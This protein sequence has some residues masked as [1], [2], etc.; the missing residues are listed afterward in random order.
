[1]VG[2][3]F[4][5]FATNNGIAVGS[6][7]GRAALRTIP[8]QALDIVAA[9]ADRIYFRTYLPETFDK[10]I[11]YEISS[12]R[13]VEPFTIENTQLLAASGFN[14]F[15]RGSVLYSDCSGV[16]T[17]LCAQ[18]LADGTTFM[19]GSSSR[20]AVGCTVSD[21]AYR[22]GGPYLLGIQRLSLVRRGTSQVIVSPDA[23]DSDVRPFL[24]AVVGDR[25]YFSPGRYPSSGSEGATYI[26]L[27]YEMPLPPEPCVA[28][29]PC[30][31]GKTCGADNLCH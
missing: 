6:L 3:S 24:F 8:A 2:D 14:A 26:P 16:D 22:G 28:D 23:N 17:G 11:R 18:D 29:L 25:L 30:P 1:M 19:L 21:W 7:D 20:H 9:A 31:I 5:A 13:V 10:P 4:V 27:L 12:V 15:V